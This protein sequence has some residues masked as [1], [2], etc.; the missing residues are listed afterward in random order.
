MVLNGRYNQVK[1]PFNAGED[2]LA[3]GGAID[4]ITPESTRPIIY[5]LGI[6]AP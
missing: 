6:I 4:I 3:P 1:G 5:K 2:L